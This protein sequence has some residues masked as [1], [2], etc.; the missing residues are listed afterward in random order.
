[1]YCDGSRVW[2]LGGCCQRRPNVQ[3]NFKNVLLILFGQGG[4]GG[5]GGGGGRGKDKLWCLWRE[6]TPLQSF[7][8]LIAL[9]QS[10]L[11][12]Q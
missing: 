5:G 1:M 2:K 6:I 4:G 8:K 10:L 3:H 9:I 12:L 7:H 11:A